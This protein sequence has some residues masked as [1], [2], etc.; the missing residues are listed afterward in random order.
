MRRG[1]AF[2]LQNDIVLPYF[3]NYGTE[4]QKAKYLPGM[5]TGETIT[6][7]A[8]TE[9]N[10]GSDLQG[11]RTTAVKRGDSY[12]LNGQ[13]TFITNG[14]LNDVCIVVAKTNPDAGRRVRACSSSTA[15]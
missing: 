5:V 11:I 9:P 8:M 12:L 14:M 6:A 13:K 15:R 3:L 4:A 2:R 7:I 1:R 10:T